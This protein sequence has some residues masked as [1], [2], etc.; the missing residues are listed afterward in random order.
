MLGIGA[1]SLA[2]GPISSCTS[3]GS[4]FFSCNVYPTNSSGNSATDTGFIPFPAGSAAVTAGYAIFLQPGTVDNPAN[5][6]N[7][8]DWNEVL[9]FVGDLNAGASSDELELF[10]GAAMP[11]YSTVNN[12]NGGGADFFLV[13]NA[14][15][16]YTFGSPDVYTVFAASAPEPASVAL[17]GGAMLGLLALR[18]RT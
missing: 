3:A 14:N 5:E 6:Q 4:G 17:V 1:L 10:S 2:A 8:G 11:S 18:R 13:Q 12:Y 7:T 16:I 15:G 9:F